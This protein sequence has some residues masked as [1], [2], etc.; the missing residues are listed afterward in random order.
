MR[1]FSFFFFTEKNKKKAWNAIHRGVVYLAIKPMEGRG[2]RLVKDGTFEKLKTKTLL[3]DEDRT[4]KK[5][6]FLSVFFC[7]CCLKTSI[8]WT[9]PIP[10][11]PLPSNGLGFNL[12]WEV[13]LHC[14]INSRIKRQECG[15]CFFS[16]SLSPP[17]PRP[18]FC[19]F[20]VFTYPDSIG[21]KIAAQQW[22]R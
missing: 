7:C 11:P 18:F 8:N 1:Y 10:P 20:L 15:R 6:T 13:K 2:G 12:I 19:D 21:P 22:G 9:Q 5:N 14:D 3:T 4:R 16:S 17:P